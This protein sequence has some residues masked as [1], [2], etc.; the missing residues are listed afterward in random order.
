MRYPWSYLSF[1]WDD[2]GYRIFRIQSVLDAKL[3]GGGKVTLA[4]M[5][6]LQTDHVMTVAGP[7]IQYL[8]A[9]AQAAQIPDG[10]SGAAATILLAWGS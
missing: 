1:E 6:A 7:F 9:L 3:A 2:Q 4:D 8:G 10:N 5:Q